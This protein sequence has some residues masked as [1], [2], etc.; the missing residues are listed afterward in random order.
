MLEKGRFLEKFNKIFF[1]F[2][3][4]FIT[5]KAFADDLKSKIIDYNNNLKNSSALFIQTDGKTIE[6]GIVY[7]GL[8]RIKVEYRSP[9]KITIVL[10]KKRGMY[11][12]HELQETQ[13]FNTKKSVV[14]I[15]FKIL[16]GDDFFI[17]SKITE[18][19][20]TITI[21]KSFKINDTD[22]GVEI[23][24]ENEPI[25]LRKIKFKENDQNFEIGLFNYSNFENT[26]K[27]FYSLINPYISN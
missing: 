2:F 27:G 9:Q 6:E 16:T 21:N 13:Y 3:I 10:S 25:Q 18:F 8:E 12:N 1:L 17:N 20:D 26:E 22:Y 24:Y 15:F 5:E 7:I 4:F 11:V 14:G 19:K 23:V